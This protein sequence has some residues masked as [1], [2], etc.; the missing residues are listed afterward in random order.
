MSF[1]GVRTLWARA[2]FLA[3]SAPLLMAGP[4]PASGATIGHA[5][6]PAV[7]AESQVDFSADSEADVTKPPPPPPCW[8]LIPLVCFKPDTIRAAYG[9]QPMLDQGITGRGTTIVVIGAYSD[10]NI[11]DDLKTFDTIWKIPHQ[12]KLDLKVIDLG[13][14]TFDPNPMHVQFSFSLEIAIDVEWAHAVAPDAKIV[15]VEAKS[16]EDVDLVAALQYAVDN[17]LGDVITQSFGEAE[18]C[19]P[20]AVLDQ[21]HAA[22]QKAAEL[23]ITVFAS[24]GDHGAA[25]QS[26]DGTGWVLSASTPASDPQVTAVGGTHLVAGAGGTYQSELA[27]TRPKAASGGGFSTLYRR[28]GYQA[29]LQKDDNK[30][31]GVPDVS[32]AAESYVARWMTHNALVAGTSAGAPQWA[33]IVALADQDA[34]HR[35]GSINKTLY[36]IAKSDAYSSAFNDI[37]SGGN[38]LMGINGYKAKPGWDPVTGLGTPI[39]NNLIPLLIDGEE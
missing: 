2:A 25:R 16:K 13:V 19:T 34:G 1:A 38:S 6:A 18:M 4:I 21:Q 37:S 15:L 29:P 32:Y 9:I 17:N 8:E 10:P 23:G 36:H 31:R 12:E 27:W 5:M 22:F 3:L 28:P 39:V 11:Q 26:C 24:S 7:D 33:G 35:L 30:A 14:P 20:Q